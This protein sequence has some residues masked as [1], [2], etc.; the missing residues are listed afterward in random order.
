MQHP[1]VDTT[2]HSYIQLQDSCNAQLERF[3]LLYSYEVPC[4]MLVTDLIER[5]T[6]DMEASPFSYQFTPLP[7]SSAAQYPHERLALQILGFRNRGSTR[8]ME[9]SSRL[10]SVF[11]DRDQTLAGIAGDKHRF[12]PEH[13]IEGNHFVLHMSK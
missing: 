2:L 4:S 11:V 12:V 5:V 7:A 1:N 13:A 8:N 6:A 10:R 9:N 3:H